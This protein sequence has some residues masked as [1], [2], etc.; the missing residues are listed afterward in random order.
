MDVSIIAIGDELLIGQ[1]TDTNSG[2][3]AR[4]LSPLGWNVHTVRVVADDSEEIFKAIDESFA[5]TN[6]VLCTGGLGPTKDDIT[7]PTLC[8][9]FG[10]EL[11]YDEATARNVQ[12]VVDTRHLKMNPL[13]AA[14][15]NVPS[16][17]RVIQNKV[18]TAPLMW[19]EKDGKVLVSMPGV[20]FETETMMELEVIPQLLKHFS[21]NDHIVYR[22]F[23]VIDYSES[24]LAI[25][26]D[27]FER[28]MPDY[29][30]LAY[31]PK[32]GVIRLRLTGTS[33]DEAKI[34]ADMDRLSAQLH[35]ILGDAIVCSEDKSLSEILGIKL[36]E[37]GLTVASAESCTGG[38][39]AHQ[40]TE[41]AGSSEY[42]VG[43]VVS[44][45]NRVKNALLKVPNEIL[46]TVG[47][48]SQETAEQM[49][50]GVSE[51]LGTDCAM[52]TTGIAGP[53]GAEPGKPV[54]TVWIAAK[55]GDKLVSE[56]FHFP[57]SRDRVIDRATTTAII[58]L[59]KLL[60]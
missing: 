49:S 2:W 45:C 57:G 41:I 13:T 34:I 59:L 25:K 51:L 20:P 14:Q 30:H 43:T 38:N 39:I 44:Y 27:E 6:I 31:L 7:K 55:Y 23:I 22:T 58:M 32:P 11:V 28:Q 37:K 12:E 50:R 26:L 8:R 54:G 46:D 15:A 35:D 56:C 47:A 33:K 53:G 5:E 4:H 18:G 1:V 36:R 19:F 29:I 42:F 21:V 52:S 3:I 17:C 9:Y 16:S 24:V 40:I 10:G 60:K 48:V